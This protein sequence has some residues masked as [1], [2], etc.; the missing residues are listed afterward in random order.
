M[1]KANKQTNKRKTFSKLDAI[2]QQH[3]ILDVRGPTLSSHSMYV[4][5]VKIYS[6]YTMRKSTLFRI[7]QANVNTI[8]I[9]EKH[10]LG[11][12]VRT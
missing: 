8:C 12:V 1:V 6:K 5:R 3:G 9:E 2:R 10:T 4:N 11:G 7:F